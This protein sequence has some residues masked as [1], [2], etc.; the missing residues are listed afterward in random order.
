MTLLALPLL[1][2]ARRGSPRVTLVWLRG[3]LGYMTC[4]HL[5]AEAIER[6][7]RQHEGADACL[8]R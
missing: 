6:R 1:D 2:A 8:K 4:L 7:M 3:L 5:V